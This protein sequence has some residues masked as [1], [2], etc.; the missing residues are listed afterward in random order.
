M[1]EAFFNRYALGEVRAFSA[2]TQPGDHLDP[3]VV[4]IMEELGIDISSQRPKLLTKEMLGRADRIVTMGCGEEGFCP[5]GFV[6]TEDWELEDPQGKPVESVREIRDEIEVKVKELVEEMQQ[7]QG[8]EA[9]SQPPEACG[10]YM[11]ADGNKKGKSK[12]GRET[13]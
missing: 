4:G 8:G 3:T 6:P 5:A 10:C 9:V 12:G 11:E 1:A 13:V 7:E 2:G